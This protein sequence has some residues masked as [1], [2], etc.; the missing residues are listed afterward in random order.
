MGMPGANACRQEAY[1]HQQNN[2]LF[3]VSF[4]SGQSLDAK[5][6]GRSA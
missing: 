6:T 5:Y 4:S 1:R 3:H 2:A